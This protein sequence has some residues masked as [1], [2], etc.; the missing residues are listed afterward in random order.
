MR[1]LFVYKYLT[2]GGVEAVLRARLDGLGCAGI[3]AHAWFFHDYG[4]VSIFAGLED[5]IHLGSVEEC[6]LYAVEQEF[7]LL[8]S[9]DSEEVLP[10]FEGPSGRLRLVMECHSAYPESLDYLRRLASH[11]PAAVFTPSETH[12]Q[13][14]RER[15]GAGI[16]PRVVPNPLRREL[17]AELAP[18]GPVPPRPVVAWIGRLDEHK[19]WKSFLK[20][21]ELLE[22]RNH[23]NHGVELW[24][25]GRPVAADGTAA[26][27]ERSR[28]AVVLGRLRWF[29]GLPHDRIPFFF[30]AVRDSGGVAVTTSRGESFGM[31]VVEAMARGCAVLV[32]DQGPFTEYVEEGVTGSLYRPGSARSAADHL[33]ALLADGGLREACGRRARVSVLERFAPEPALAVLAAE[34][35][36]AAAVPAAADQ[37]RSAQTSV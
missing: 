3:E 33:Q 26:L 16:E 8:C 35:E 31:T 30:D 22:R 12:R 11:H 5:R 23:R 14:V 1:V 37:R 15:I 36:R 9:I 29:R 28:A 18:F 20:I 4:G 25:A 27:F 21:A 34:L 13:I 19:N 10:G 7:D 2:L 17:V 32:P 24:M 6:L